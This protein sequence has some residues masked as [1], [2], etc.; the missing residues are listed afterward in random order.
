[1]SVTRDKQTKHIT[2]GRQRGRE[3]RNCLSA[4]SSLTSRRTRLDQYRCPGPGCVRLPRSLRTQI[5]P[6][7]TFRPT[8]APCQKLSPTVPG[9]PA[10]CRSRSGPVLPRAA[11]CPRALTLVGR[12]GVKSHA[13]MGKAGA[14]GLLTAAAAV[15]AAGPV[16]P[17]TRNTGRCCRSSHL[18]GT[19]S[20]RS[21]NVSNGPCRPRRWS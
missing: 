17:H 4:Q 16:P 20:T 10:V 1:M 13:A 9:Q 6:Q 5:T 3:P 7:I 21:A 8:P 15:T 14:A 12:A 11:P 2:C 18:C 19:H